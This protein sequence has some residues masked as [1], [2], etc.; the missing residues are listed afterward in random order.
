[1][2]RFLAGAVALAFV[3]SFSGPLFAKTATIKGQLVDQE[4]YLTEKKVET[5]R[6]VRGPVREVRQAGRT[7]HRGWKGL[8]SHRRTRREQEREA[9][10]PH[11]L[12]TVE[13][14]GDVTEKGGKLSIAADSL[15]MAK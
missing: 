12:H 4:C 5:D 7:A 10:R 14:T 2:R 1:M 6:H 15:K 11:V 9:D 8:R 13:I 3:A